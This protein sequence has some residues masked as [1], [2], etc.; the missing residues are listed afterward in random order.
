MGTNKEK[1]KK[2]G[3]P[4]PSPT[5]QSAEGGNFA[6]QGKAARIVQDSV[7]TY[8][9]KTSLSPPAEDKEETYVSPLAASMHETM[10]DLFEL[11][12]VDERTMRQFDDS[13]LTAVREFDG[14]AIR[15]LR[16]REQASQAVFAR[17]LGVS[18]N[19]IG[20]WERG[21]RKAGGAAAKLLALVDRYGLDYIK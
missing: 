19:A 11:G 7:T 17:Y 1:T 20:Q 13:C 21:E 10:A 16:M 2:S 6:R 4:T 18:L 15:N 14:E 9:K 12:L 3:E 5:R 8:P